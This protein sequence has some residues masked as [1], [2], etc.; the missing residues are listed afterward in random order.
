MS[1]AEIALPRPDAVW[2]W[3]PWTDARG[4]FSTFK[5]TVFMLLCLPALLLAFDYVQGGLGARPLKELLLATG[6]WSI[7]LILVSLALSPARAVLQWPKLSQVRRMVGV[8]AFAYVLAHFTLY[9]A[10][11]AFDL[12]KVAS[13]IVLRIYLAIGFTALLA[14][15]ALAATSTDGMVRRLGG[16]RWRLLHRLVYGAG[17]LAVV[18]FFMQSKSNVDE[19]WVMAGL[20]VWLL[21]WRALAWWRRPPGPAGLALLA[22]AVAVLTAVGEAVYFW[23]KMGVPP[24]RV[25]EAN[26]MWSLAPRP[27]AAVLAIAL[28]VV[29]AALLRRPIERRRA[30]SVP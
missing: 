21:A 4:R 20:L 15:A 22:G 28:A 8:G 2:R 16:K 7:R 18:H 26:W 30:A 25:L 13:E 19:P 10:D 24:L 23:L 1:V 11:Q 3:M 27:A 6:L 9:A 12:A 14:L 17:V 29:L 5:C